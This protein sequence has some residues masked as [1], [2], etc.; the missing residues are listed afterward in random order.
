MRGKKHDGTSITVGDCYNNAHSC[1]MY[2]PLNGGGDEDGRGTGSGYGIHTPIIYGDTGCGAGTGR[3]SG[4]Q[5]VQEEWVD[6][7]S[8][9]H[10]SCD[11][12]GSS[13]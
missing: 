5:A 12:D 3:G 4:L 7:D 2:T 13:Y 11:R 6:D 1:R 10:G 9:L 8:T